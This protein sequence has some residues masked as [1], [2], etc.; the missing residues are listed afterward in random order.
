MR[1]IDSSVVVNVVVYYFGPPCS[2]AHSVIIEIVFKA[3]IK[4]NFANQS[5]TCTCRKIRR[6]ETIFQ[7]GGGGVMVTI[8]FY[9]VT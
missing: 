5:I 7:R 6:S 1:F 4:N 8:K 9:H 2:N 3:F